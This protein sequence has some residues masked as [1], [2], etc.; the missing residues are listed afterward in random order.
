[1]IDGSTSSARLWNIA[2]FRLTS[3]EDIKKIKANIPELLQYRESLLPKIELQ[4]I[5][6]DFINS[7]TRSQLRMPNENVNPLKNLIRKKKTMLHPEKLNIL[8]YAKHRYL[9]VIT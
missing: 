6:F 9:E 5:A 4:T 3:S 2:S 1:M 7:R 8:I